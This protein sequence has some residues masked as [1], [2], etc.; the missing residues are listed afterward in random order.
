MDYLAKKVYDRDSGKVI[1]YVLDLA[2]DFQTLSVTGLYVVDEESEGEYLLRFADVEKVADVVIVS[3]LSR[4]E[5]VGRREKGLLGKEVLSV[6]GTSLGVVDGLTF[7]KKKI[8]SICT[9]LCEIASKL[10][11]TIGEDCIFLKGKAK[12]KKRQS[13]F[14]VV[15]GEQKVEVMRVSGEGVA[16]ERINLSYNF[17]AG[18]LAT[19]DVFGYNNERIVEKNEKITKNIFENA[20]KHNKLNELFFVIKK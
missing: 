13:P 3:D 15:E 5:F 2:I 17:F 1:G 8:K 19:G 16:P 14:Q 4:L 10:V 20:K 6:D 9:N 11:G 7:E 12:R 18:K